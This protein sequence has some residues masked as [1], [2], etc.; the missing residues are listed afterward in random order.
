MENSDKAVALEVNQRDQKKRLVRYACYLSEMRGLLH[1][2]KKEARGL[3]AFFITQREQEK[4][5][6]AISFFEARIQ[7]TV[8]YTLKNLDA[9]QQHAW[10]E[11]ADYGEDRGDH[12]GTIEKKG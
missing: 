4:Q 3:E 11:L 1:E 10:R 8:Y 7:A 6:H 12:D 9:Y 2:I 5:Q